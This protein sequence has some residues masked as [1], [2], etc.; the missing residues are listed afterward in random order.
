MI[1]CTR[2]SLRRDSSRLRKNFF[3]FFRLCCPLSSTRTTGGKRRQRKA[4]L[5]K[6]FSLGGFFLWLRSPPRR[7]RQKWFHGADPLSDSSSS[8]QHLFLSH[9]PPLKWGLTRLIKGK[10]RGT[11]ENKLGAD[12]VLPLLSRK[13]IPHQIFVPI[14]VPIS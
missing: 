8:F 9:S 13:K 4:F 14:F 3:V 12:S 11:K 5:S 7:A 6:Y 10:P 2:R 1:E